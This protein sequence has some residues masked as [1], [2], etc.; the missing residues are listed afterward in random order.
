MGGVVHATYFCAD[1]K[2][3]MS[4]LQTLLQKVYHFLV[5]GCEEEVIIIQFPKM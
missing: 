4:L 5:F 1:F 3:L 2:S